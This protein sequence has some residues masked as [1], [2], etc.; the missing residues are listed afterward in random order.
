MET[1]SRLFSIGGTM[2][3]Q[4]TIKGLPSYITLAEADAYMLVNVS[5]TGWD[6]VPTP[7]E[8]IKENYILSAYQE[9]DPDDIETEA[10]G[11]RK[12]LNLLAIIFMEKA[13]FYRNKTLQATGVKGY[14]NSK[15]KVEFSG[16]SLS[17][18]SSSTADEGGNDIIDL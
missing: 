10:E 1:A 15:L 16:Q 2:D 12:Q 3:G 14:T 7:S 6:A 13:D 17:S 5:V 9:I 4:E 11:K 18:S 8:D